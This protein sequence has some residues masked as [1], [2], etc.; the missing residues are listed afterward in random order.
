MPPRVCPVARFA[1]ERGFNSTQCGQG[2]PV[3]LLKTQP[4][5]E[6]VSTLAAIGSR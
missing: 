2:C 3:K 6:S 5:E 1:G 4:T